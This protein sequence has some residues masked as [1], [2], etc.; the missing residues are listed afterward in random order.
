M[1]D[2]GSYQNFFGMSHSI[3]LWMS[4]NFSQLYLYLE[5]RKILKLKIKN[6]KIF[7]IN[8]EQQVGTEQFG[9][10]ID[11]VVFFKPQEKKN[12]K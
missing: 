8:P 7:K 5:N 11:F 10:K 9:I 2:D 6:D 12:K 3:L 4:L 1:N